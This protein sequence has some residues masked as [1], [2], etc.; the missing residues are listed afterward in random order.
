MNI[1]LKVRYLSA[2]FSPCKLILADNEDI[3]I[4]MLDKGRFAGRVVLLCNGKAYVCTNKT[5]TISR[6][7]LANVNV[8]ELQERDDATDKILQVVTVENLLVVPCEKEYQDNRLLTERT[9]YAEVITELLHRVTALQD[10]LKETQK[11]VLDLENGKYT[12]LKFGGNHE[13]I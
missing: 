6:C 12:L 8:F 4:T 1:N 10:Q 13:E 3:T 2:Y 9:F 5:V 11:R 7:E